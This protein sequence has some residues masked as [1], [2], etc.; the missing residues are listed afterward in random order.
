[1]PTPLNVQNAIDDLKQQDPSL[2][3]YSDEALYKHLKRT[4][5]SLAW[6][7]VDSGGGSEPN[8]SP[9]FMN[10]FQEWFDYG[11]DENSYG[12]M[13]SAYN[14]SLTGLTEQLVTGKQRYD[15][16]DYDPNILEDIGSMAL[17][18]TMPLDIIAMA[19]VVEREA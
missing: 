15:I 17:S 1:M 12:W 10:A 9:T 13:K 8:T 7:D 5:I 19:A 14:N 16:K 6:D 3:S 4:D 18:F 11:I 2:A